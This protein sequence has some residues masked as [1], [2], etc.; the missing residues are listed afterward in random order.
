MYYLEDNVQKIKYAHTVTNK[1]VKDDTGRFL[2]F[3]EESL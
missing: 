1:E 3:F 2:S